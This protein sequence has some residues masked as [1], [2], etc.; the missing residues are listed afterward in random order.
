MSVTVV[1]VLAVAACSL[2]LC[3]LIV[4]YDERA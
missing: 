4:T 3:W 2:R 1:L